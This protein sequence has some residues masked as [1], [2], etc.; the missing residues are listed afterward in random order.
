MRLRASLTVA[1][2]GDQRGDSSIPSD[3]RQLLEF[4]NQL[5]YG[6]RGCRREKTHGHEVRMNWIRKGWDGASIGCRRRLPASGTDSLGCAGESRWP[7]QAA[8]YLVSIMTA[9][10]PT[11][12]RLGLDPILGEHHP[13]TLYFAAVAISAWYGGFWPGAL[14]ILLSYFAAD[15]FFIS[16]R[17][18]FK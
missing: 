7:H 13:F 16:P 9:G 5:A 17:F 2:H 10:L 8:I 3:R 6:E 14:S 11:G 15:W 12:C 4:L 1:F 18:Q